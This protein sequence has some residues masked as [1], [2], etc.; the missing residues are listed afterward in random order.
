MIVDNCSTDDSYALLCSRYESENRVDMIRNERNGGYGQGNNL[1]IRYSIDTYQVDTVGIINPDVLIPDMTVI[2]T[3]LD[4]LYSDESYA[5]VGG[6]IIDEDG[7]EHINRSGWGIQ[8]SLQIIRDHF[9]TYDPYAK[10]HDMHELAPGILSTEC[11]AGCFFLARIS[12]FREMGLFDE[13]IFLY[14]EESVLGI[15]CR[16]RGYKEVI[17]T[18]ARYY[19]NHRERDEQHMTFLKKIRATKCDYDSTAYICRKY[20]SPLLIPLLGMVECF[21]RIYLALA[22]VY[23]KVCSPKGMINEH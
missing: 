5:V 15:E 18:G 20:Y 1:G 23:K 2:D 13:N 21:N 9:I 19:H 8:S 3:M 17:A 14:H 11:V 22:F 12:L 7:R 4:A 10:A 6:V 16:R